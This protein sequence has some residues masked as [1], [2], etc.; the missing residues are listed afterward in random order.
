[1]K[2][3]SEL[4][5]IAKKQIGKTGGK[6]RKYVG[7]GGS[8][9]DMFVFWLYDAN[10]CGSLLPWKG[11]QRY[12]CPASYKWCQKHLA[13]I[14]PYLAM[15]CDPIYFDWDKNGNPNHIGIVEKRRTAN[16]AYTIEGNTSGGKVDDKV[17]KNYIQAVFRPHFRPGYLKLSM[18][19]IDGYFGYQSIANFQRALGGLTIDGILGKATVKRLQQYLAITQDGFW[20]ANT[21]RHL[22]KMLQ[23][24]GFYK[25]PIDAQFEAGSVK[26]LQRWIN[27]KN[28][29]NQNTKPIKV[30]LP[31]E[32]A[33]VE[34]TK[35]SKPKK[36]NAQKIVAEIHK[37]AWKK[38]TPKKNYS[39]KKGRP[40]DAMKKAL[41]KYGYDTKAEMS[42]C[43][44]NVNVVVR[45]SG[46]DKH[47]TSLH[48]V[49]TPF[50]KH[51]DKFKIVISGRV[52]KVKEMKAGDIIRYKKKGGKD[53]HA[54]FYLGH[55][56]IADAGHYNR[57]FN[58]RKNDF[59]YKRRNV[60]KSTI[61]VLR[62]KEK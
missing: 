19:D 12:F 47:F 13:Q 23:K 2:T 11:S 55:N 7:V 40:R 45:G 58:I 18:L 39:Y 28:Q 3:N 61:Q 14:P 20:G 4:L 30:D 16:S 52:P 41:R 59:R 35:V 29:K 9:C 27:D 34:D 56:I 21:S 53:Q 50:P 6:Y 60:K 1:M 24:N 57:F 48:A 33:P 49:K 5:K 8:W 44:N 43:G 15:E 42:D 22:Q 31:K 37:L 32:E 51:E 46:V 54:M 26:A 38:G 36:T 17:R 62:A 10:G 25:G